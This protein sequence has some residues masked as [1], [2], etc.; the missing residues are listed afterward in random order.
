MAPKHLQH[1]YYHQGDPTGQVNLSNSCS[2][3]ESSNVSYHRVATVDTVGIL[4]LR[5]LSFLC[6]L[7]HSHVDD[8]ALGE[9]DS[10]VALLLRFLPI[11]YF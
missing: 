5:L 4:T 7:S 10:E 9:K 1:C 6:L 11:I 2:E 3:C 8:I